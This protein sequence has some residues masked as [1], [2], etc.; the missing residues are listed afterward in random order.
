MNK[1]IT[2]HVSCR[3]STVPVEQLK[4]HSNIEV[5]VE[6][7]H[8]RRTIRWY[9]RFQLCKKCSI[10]A[11]AFNTSPKGRKITWGDK[12][13]KAKKGVKATEEHKR[14][15]SV[16]QYGIDESEWSGF[17]HKSDVAKI[18]DSIEYKEFR[19]QVM[20][21]DGF[22]CALT[23]K[24]GH[25][26]VHHIVGVSLDPSKILDQNNAI[27]LHED[28]HKAFHSHFGN[29]KNTPEQF[30]EFKELLLKGELEY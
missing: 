17:Y 27:T 19:N 12:I 22:C 18:R 1:I 15:L 28:V 6:C 9:R 4:D 24:Q 10:E 23:G 3:G 25:L 5:E 21:R 29:K 7:Q 16:A 8:G 20:R 14:A 11:G 2:T 26:T 30:N 13:S